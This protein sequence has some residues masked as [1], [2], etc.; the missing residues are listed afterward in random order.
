M[1]QVTSWIKICSLIKSHSLRLGRIPWRYHCGCFVWVELAI[2]QQTV[3]AP[4]WVAISWEVV[5][6]TART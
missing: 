6:T 2:D 5:L 4:L 3:C 1:A